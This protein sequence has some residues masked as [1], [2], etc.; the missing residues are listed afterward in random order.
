M[1]ILLITEFFPDL[2]TKRFSGGV[3][4]RTFF[5]AK[6]LSEKHQVTVIS[7]RKYG[8]KK[9][10]K[11]YNLEIIRLGNKTKD[12]EAKLTSIFPRFLFIIQSIIYGLKVQADLIE[13][14]NFI[15]LMPA[16]FIAKLKKVPAIAWYPDIYGLEWI[17]N[18][19]LTT[20]LLGLILEKID[21]ILPWSGVIALSKQTKKKLLEAGM[22]SKKINVIYGGVDIDY[23]RKIKARKNRLPTVCC[24]S[25]LVPYK[26]VDILIK[27]ISL[28]KEKIPKIKCLIVGKGP[29]KQKLIK[30]I[31]ELDISD[32]VDLRENLSYKE[33]IENLKSNWV[34][35]LPSRI[36]GFGLA[37][38]EALAAG[39]P[40][41]IAD[42]SINKEITR[43]KGGLFFK[44]KDPLDL[45]K[46]IFM[47]LESS[48]LRKK[49][50]IQGM[51]LIKE[52]DWKKISDKTEK[53]YKSISV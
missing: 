53:V 52:Y 27:A 21:L 40:F 2:K 20:G 37:T 25:R 22:K 15:C 34:F 4:V 44:K 16:Y 29:E 6:N 51:L 3:E 39:L 46:K 48:E 41:V 36:E 24:V 30:L 50:V 10:E 47:L 26:N 14:S 35:C 18:F 45:S 12:I 5:I 49:L 1:K 23:I 32:N 19:G 42:I 7:R 33:L 8:E 28:A 9:K 38:I 43:N 11:H 17:N 31:K 13:G